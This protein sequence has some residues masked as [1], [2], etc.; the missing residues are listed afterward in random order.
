[1]SVFLRVLEYYAGILFLT[2]NRVGSFDEA[3]RSRIHLSLYYPPL[4]KDST[5]KIWKNNLDRIERSGRLAFNREKIMGFADKLFKNGTRWNGRQI[6]NAFQ[7]AISLAGY[8]QTRKLTLDPSHVPAKPKLT[9][10]HF[11]KVAKA[12]ADFDEYVKEVMGG[13]GYSEKAEMEELRADSF[14]I[15]S[16]SPK[17][18]IR[19]VRGPTSPP[20]KADSSINGDSDEDGKERRKAKQRKMRRDKNREKEEKMESAR[21]GKESA[22]AV[23]SLDDSGTS[24]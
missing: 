2:T 16:V 13:Q 20:S 11:K 19:A 3:F 15:D 14:R 7:T 24:D 17:P 9:K 18:K 4:D 6:R 22:A 23:S 10:D 5:T 1:M 21:R 12:S 8:D